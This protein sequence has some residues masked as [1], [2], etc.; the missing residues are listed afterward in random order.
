M[1]NLIQSQQFSLNKLIQ[2]NA[3]GTIKND[4]NEEK[5]TR[6]ENVGQRVRVLLVQ[7]K[8]QY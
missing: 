2:W 5:G 1:E 7:T 3:K 4:C 8:W 6:V